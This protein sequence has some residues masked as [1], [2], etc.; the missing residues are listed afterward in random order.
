MRV[1][2]AFL[3]R[4]AVG[5]DAV[6]LCGWSQSPDG[7]ELWVKSRPHVRAK[8]KTLTEAEDAFLEAIREN[9][10]AFHAVMEFIPPLPR[11]ERDQKYTTPEIYSLCGDESFSTDEPKRIPFETEPERDDREAW[12]DLFFTA[13]C[14]RGCF[15]PQGPRNSR[16]LM[17]TSRLK[18]YD[19]AFASFAGASPRAFSETFLELLTAE[20]RRG[21]RFQLI[22]RPK[23]SRKFFFE[24]VGP[25][26]P[27][28][29]AVEGMELAGWQCKQCGRRVFGPEYDRNNLIHDFV[30]MSDLPKP[31]P[32]VFTI[33]PHYRLQLCMTA[34]R[35]ATLVGK[36]G[37]RGIV[38]QLVGVVPDDEVVREPELPLM[39]L[40]RRAWKEPP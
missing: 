37:T 12:Y 27:L 9:G 33:G 8:G 4:T 25:E 22:V 24:L 19:G 11:S 30:A 1:L 32:S 39:E 36:P 18:N 2:A 14:C 28:P 21:L 15:A 20:E 10:G 23:K 7:F 3:Q 26:G 6:Y 29:V 16:R 38:S 31:L 34:E 5:R 17:T 35:W 13:P 40:D